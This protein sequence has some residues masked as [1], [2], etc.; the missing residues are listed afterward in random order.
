GTV[1]VT[2]VPSPE[3]SDDLPPPS[4]PNRCRPILPP[5]ST[6]STP[7]CGTPNSGG[8]PMLPCGNQT[9]PVRA[10]MDRCPTPP[11]A[12]LRF[13]TGSAA[14]LPSLPSIPRRSHKVPALLSVGIAV[15]GGSSPE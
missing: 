13:H 8:C 14:E 3:I 1:L 7:W 4:S 9:P 5:P 15:L 2:P 6:G 12:P 10:T 11:D